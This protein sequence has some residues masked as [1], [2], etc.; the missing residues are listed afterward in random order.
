MNHNSLHDGAL[1]IFYEDHFFSS[2][3]EL[4][5]GESVAVYES[6]SQPI[7]HELFELVLLEMLFFVSLQKVCYRFYFLYLKVEFN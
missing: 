6:M 2:F 3:E 4:P 1:R 7:V 5:K